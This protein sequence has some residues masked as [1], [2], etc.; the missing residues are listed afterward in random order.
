MAEIVQIIE[1]YDIGG[2]VTLASKTHS[3]FRYQ[4][5]SWSCVSLVENGIRVKA[6]KKDYD[7][8]DDWHRTMELSFHVL[9]QMRDIAA[10]TF[11]MV[12]DL[13]KKI[14]GK[15]EVQHEPYYDFRPHE[16]GDGFDD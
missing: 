11:M 2:S 13:N 10:Q 7:S 3:E 6:L 4:F 14:E 15:I 9:Y 1:R 8:I 12:E 5:P 16:P